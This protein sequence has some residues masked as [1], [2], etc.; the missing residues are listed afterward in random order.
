[1]SDLP[2]SLGPG[3]SGWVHGHLFER[4]V[5]FL[6]GE[7]HA[8]AATGLA[9][10]LMTLE[11]SGD[12]PVSLYIDSHDG[13]LEAAFVLIDTI[14]LLRAQ[15]RAHCLG[16][17]GGPSVGVLAAADRR[18][19]SPHARFRLAQPHVQAEGTVDRLSA[20]TQHLQDLLRRF[21]LQLAEATGQPL[22]EVVLDLRR[23]RYL[24]AQEA[25]AYGLIHE[26]TGRP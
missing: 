19:A 22:E 18:T 2:P 4:R 8:A 10:Q 5:L 12:E 15:V 23:G 21:Q 1:M 20:E 24:D 6:S 7:L 26:I 9:A 17:V 13:T 14:K 25:L 3:V 11:A 16:R